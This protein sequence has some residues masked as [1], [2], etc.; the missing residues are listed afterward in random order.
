MTGPGTLAIH[1]LPAPRLLSGELLV[2]V[3]GCT[4]CGS[5]LHTF[6]GRRPT[7]LPCLLGHEI[8]GR[9]TAIGPDLASGRICDLAGNP[10]EIGDRIVWAI[11]A[12]CGNCRR[13][14][15]GLPQKCHNAIK[16]GHTAVTH[17]RQLLGGLASHCLL[18]TGSRAVRLP[19]SLPLETAC[20]ASCATATVV[21]ALEPAGRLDGQTVVVSG[22]G[23]LGLTAVA[24][25]REAGA[26]EVI[27]VDP[28][29]GRRHRGL[30]FGATRTVVPGE[31][32][33]ILQ[34]TG[35]SEAAADLVLEMSGA[36]AAV[37]AAI[38]ACGIGGSVHCV[39]SVFPAGE[40]AVDPEQIVRRQ[41]TIRGIHNYA[42]RHLQTAVDFLV[43][44]HSRYPFAS[45]VEAWYPLTEAAEAFAAA[46]RGDQIRVGVRGS[47][48]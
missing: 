30:A 46:G 44:C 1:H 9:V 45:L 12:A 40:I 16:Y 42:P 32:R 27:G 7:A 10:I 19:D 23:M 38:A 35:P 20:P 18:V 21:A 37:S 24:M 43:S 26:A 8:V 41:L 25:A 5:D 6:T 14:R 48:N 11:V 33:K 2:E 22:L 47:P 13:C 4:L 36:A 17:D 31:L 3:L 29:P 28:H 39:G 15:R 34:A